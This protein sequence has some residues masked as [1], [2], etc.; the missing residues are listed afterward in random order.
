MTT[1]EYYEQ[2]SHTANKIMVLIINLPWSM[3]AT[4]CSMIQEV[5]IG[6]T[7]FPKAGG[8]KHQGNYIYVCQ[9]FYLL[10]AV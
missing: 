8:T 4:C 6:T 10:H 1:G 3:I 2:L 7:V 5:A 9:D